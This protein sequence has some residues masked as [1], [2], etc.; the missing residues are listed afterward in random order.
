MVFCL[1]CIC[2]SLLGCKPFTFTKATIKHPAQ[3][4]WFFF[5]AFQ[6]ISSYR[7]SGLGQV[8]FRMWGVCIV[9]FQ[10]IIW[11]YT[12]N[13]L[14]QWEWLRLSQ[15]VCRGY[16]SF[17]WWILWGNHAEGQRFPG[18]SLV[19]CV[20]LIYRRKKGEKDEECTTVPPI[21]LDANPL[22]PVF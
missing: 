5:L 22:K 6:R 13:S 10:W 20:R 1:I 7:C 12:V 4:F 15:N 9:H 11:N 16:V 18:S 19:E 3:W 14:S 2:K 8:Q 21:P 17:K